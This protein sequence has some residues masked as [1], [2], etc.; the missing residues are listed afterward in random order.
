MG[1]GRKSESRVSDP[2]AESPGLTRIGL[3]GLGK[4]GLSHCSILNAHEGVDLVGVC[5]ASG[6]ALRVLDRYTSIPTYSEM[7]KMLDET[8]PQAVVIATPSSSHAQMV[9]DC[10]GRGISVFCEK[11][12]TLNPADADELTDLARAGGLVGQVGYHNRFVGSFAEVKRLLELGAIGNVTHVLAEAYGPVV[13]KRK[14]GTW[15]SRRSEGGGCLYDYAAHVINLV[16]WYLGEPERVGGTVLNSVFS[17]DIDDEVSSVLM[18]P[19]G[20]TAQISANWS[21]ESQRKMT[22]RLTLWG[23][24]GRIFA[25]R[26]ECQIYLR[27]TAQAP[28]GYHAGWNVRYTTELTSPVAFYLRGEE[29]S[30]QIEHF[31]E[32]LAAGGLKSINDFQSAAITDS[33]I[34]R[35]VQDSVLPVEAPRQ[36]ATA[37]VRKRRRFW[38][39]WRAEA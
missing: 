9:R 21:D 8:R 32:R 16:I 7:Q 13:L 33:V 22:T 27:D 23:T 5:D 29:Y 15:R 17:S 4:M 37:A 30:A 24:L 39:L 34:E 36:A 6:L 1:W 25:D 12:F 20:A 10:L 35:M 2:K 11:P 18:Y 19:N 38:K 3:V 14:G 28:P 31:V 26:Q